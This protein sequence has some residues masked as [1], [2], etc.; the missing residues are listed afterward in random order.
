MLIFSGNANKFHTMLLHRLFR[1][2]LFYM[3]RQAREQISLFSLDVVSTANFQAAKCNY[4]YIIKTLKNMR[5]H[6]KSLETN[7]SLEIG[8]YWKYMHDVYI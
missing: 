8:V 2:V 5:V 4:I 6:R 1:V 3:S 7:L